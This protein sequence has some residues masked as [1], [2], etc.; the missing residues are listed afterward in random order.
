MFRKW[1]LLISWILFDENS[2]LLI[3]WEDLLRFEKSLSTRAVSDIFDLEDDEY[4]LLEFLV[5][6]LVFVM[7]EKS[8]I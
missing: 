2:W 1:L 4:M 7:F 3:A 8:V 6:C 5:V